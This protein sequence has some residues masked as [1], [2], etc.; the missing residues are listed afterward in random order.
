M[1]QVARVSLDDLYPRAVPDDEPV[2]GLVKLEAVGRCFLC[3]RRTPWASLHFE[4]A[5]C[6]AV[7]DDLAWWRF[8]R[9]EEAAAARE[10]AARA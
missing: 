2:P 5:I 9:S 6:S 3:G 7:C 10:E 8:W 4:A 1:S